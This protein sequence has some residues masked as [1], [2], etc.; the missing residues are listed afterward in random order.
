[1]YYVSTSKYVYNYEFI[2]KNVAITSRSPMNL[3]LIIF[4][5]SSIGVG[6]DSGARTV[7]VFNLLVK[8][9]GRINPELLG[10]GGAA[11]VLHDTVG[12]RSSTEEALLEPLVSLL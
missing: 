4:F 7:L 11:A 6:N 8:C 2:F 9:V 10:M 12:S 1:M 5:G 3:A